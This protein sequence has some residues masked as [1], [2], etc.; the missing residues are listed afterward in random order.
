MRATRR[1]LADTR[2]KG[3]EMRSLIFGAVIAASAFGACIG[4]GGSTTNGQRHALSGA[5]T[6]GDGVCDPTENHGS[7]PNDCCDLGSGSGTGTGSGSGSEWGS[8][9][10]S[11]SGGGGG[12]AWGWGAGD[13]W[14]VGAGVG[15][16]GWGSDDGSGSDGGSGDGS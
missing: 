5:G 8:G 10:D 9:S 12:D 4:S 1:G 2:V 11:G 16:G 13:G 14:G 15:A 3:S 7:C 6:C